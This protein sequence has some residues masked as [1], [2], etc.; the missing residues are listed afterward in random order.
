LP[1][2]P[3]A[4]F[5]SAESPYPMIGGGAIRT[6]SVLEYL[7]PRYRVDVISFSQEANVAGKRVAQLSSPEIRDLVV[8]HRASCLPP[9]ELTLPSNWWFLHLPHH[10]K[11][12]SHRVTRNFGRWV[13]G[14]PP[15]VDRFAGFD[16]DLRRILPGKR[17]DLAIVEHFWCAP[18][19][20]LLSRHTGRLVLNLH[21]V[22]SVWHQRCAEK[23]TPWLRWLHNKFA[24]SAR[25]LERDILPLF[26]GVLATSSVEA[27]HVA[28]HVPEA[29]ISVVP[30]G[31]PLRPLPTQVREDTIIFSGNMEYLPNQKAAVH[32]ARE[33]WPK[34]LAELPVYE[35]KI[36][37]RFADNLRNLLG[38]VPRVRFVADPRDAMMEIARSRVA[39]VPLTLGTGTRLK[40]IEAWASGCPVVSTTLGAEGL[41]CHDGQQ[42]LIEDSPDAFA[43]AVVKLIRDSE[44]A[45]RVAK[46]GRRHFESAYS[47]GT[48]WEALSRAQ[49]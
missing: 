44:L 33:I 22:E 49:I 23:A 28:E 37:G 10:S 6:A 43:S 27:R 24:R 30:N 46:E 26:H 39:V 45:A 35:W 17:Y 4:L 5:L 11:H 29:R 15:L 12:P 42:L 48:V 18:Y 1:G 38:N 20:R 36:V 47:W 32:F 8:P 13:R 9:D 40:I 34:I 21:N 3:S 41:D 19:A 14:V 2:K 25:L 31:M 16:G 7:L